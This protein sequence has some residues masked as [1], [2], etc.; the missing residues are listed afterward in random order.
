MFFVGKT[1]GFGSE[2]IKGRL[3]ETGSEPFNHTLIHTQLRKAYHT[4]KL[5]THK[6]IIFLF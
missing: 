5:M 1:Y 4:Y 6:E 2:T 3:S